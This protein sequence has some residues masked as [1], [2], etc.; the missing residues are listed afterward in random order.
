MQLK[1]KLIENINKV[2]S[3]QHLALW[4]RKQKRG[5]HRAGTGDAKGWMGDGAW[6]KLV[7]NCR[8][9][10]RLRVSSLC[11]WPASGRQRSDTGV[12][13]M[14]GNGT[15]LGGQCSAMVPWPYIDQTQLLSPLG[16]LP[17]LLPSKVDSFWKEGSILGI[18]LELNNT[19]M[20]SEIV[21]LKKKKKLS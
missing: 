18:C 21:C 1:A 9:D 7:Y 10:W 6:P 17:H 15:S 13:C 8:S 4:W 16:S 2:K 3:D 20:N 12:A 14:T 11:P 19:A 5:F